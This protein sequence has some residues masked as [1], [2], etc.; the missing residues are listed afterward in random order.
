MYD[1]SCKVAEVHGEYHVHSL[2]L[3][4]NLDEQEWVAGDSFAVSADTIAG[5][6]EHADIILLIQTGLSRIARKYDRT[7]F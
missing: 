5:D 7:L 4:E 3:W 1:F 2:L 6:S